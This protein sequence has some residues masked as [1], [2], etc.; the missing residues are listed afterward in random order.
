MSINQTIQT[1]EIT[2]FKK[3]NHLSVR[4]NENFESNLKLI[5]SLPKGTYHSK[6]RLLKRFGRE[7]KAKKR[8]S[9]K[10]FSTQQTKNEPLRNNGPKTKFSSANVSEF[11]FDLFVC[12]FFVNITQKYI[13]FT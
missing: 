5:S 7:P 11:L 12:F 8:M 3:V 1:Y 4:A 10:F 2:N 6:I 9:T 13:L